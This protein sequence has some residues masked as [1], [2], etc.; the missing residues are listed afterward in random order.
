MYNFYEIKHS[1]TKIE[2]IEIDTYMNLKIKKKLKA[3]DSH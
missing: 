2:N 1:G 3:N